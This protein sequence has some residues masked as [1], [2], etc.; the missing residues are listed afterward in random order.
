MAT[1]RKRKNL[2]GTI[3]YRA[4]IRLKGYKPESATFERL[5]DARAWASATETDMKAGRYFGTA[6]TKTLADLIDKYAQSPANQLKSWAG[7][8][9]YLDWW[10]AKAGTEMLK[11]IVGAR[12]KVPS[13]AR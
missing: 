9:R 2:D 8:K 10:R 11:E 4:V 12:L 13:G 1:I 5:T 7:V 6:K 3:S